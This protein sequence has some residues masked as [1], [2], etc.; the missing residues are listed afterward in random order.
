M[1]KQVVKYRICIVSSIVLPILICITVIYLCLTNNNLYKELIEDINTNRITS[2][3]CGN[4]GLSSEKYV[5]DDCQ[6]EQV[7]KHIKA[8]DVNK[9]VEEDISCL[10]GGGC[11]I[12]IYT[13]TVIYEIIIYNYNDFSI[14][15]SNI[16]NMN[17]QSEYYKTQNNKLECLINKLYSWFM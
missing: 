2:I 15:K 7:L 4:F 3:E 5:F 9:K 13:E 1:K 6:T 10:I 16:N 8:F 12:Y 11:D 17:F 14:I